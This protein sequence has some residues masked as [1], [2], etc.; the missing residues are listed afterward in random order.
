MF[1]QWLV[2]LTNYLLVTSKMWSIFNEHVPVSNF[3]V[4]FIIE[5]LCTVTPN[6]KFRFENPTEYSFKTFYENITINEFNILLFSIW[7]YYN[8]D[9]KNPFRFLFRIVTV[10][11]VYIKICFLYKS[12]KFYIKSFK[13]LLKNIIIKVIC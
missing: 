6:M 3:K 11:S 12:F 7:T 8:S 2:V 5:V 9:L 13:K 4:S 1:P 10:T